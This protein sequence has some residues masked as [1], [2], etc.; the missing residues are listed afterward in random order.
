MEELRQQSTS[1][2]S[3]GAGRGASLAPISSYGDLNVD[4]KGNSIATAWLH[5][6]ST[7]SLRPPVLPSHKS[8]TSALILALPPSS[9]LYQHVQAIRAQRDRHLSRWPMP[10]ITLLYPFAPYGTTHWVKAME[11]V[12]EVLARNTTFQIALGV[13][14]VD[15]IETDSPQSVSADPADSSALGVFQHSWRSSTIFLRPSPESAVQSLVHALLGHP[16]LVTYHDTLLHDSEPL[17]FEDAAGGIPTMGQVE[18]AFRPHISLGKWGGSA[19]ADRGVK[20]CQSLIAGVGHTQW[21]IDR[22]AAVRREGYEG[23]FQVMEDV[24]LFQP[25]ASRK[26]Q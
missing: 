21:D 24:S 9:P 18:R 7:M 6:P 17:A 16:E 12:R 22:V 4:T 13:G 14:S 3:A 1:W 15:V 23:E 10:H 2:E 5:S 25:I 20:W 11:A 19:D 8:Y 26:Y